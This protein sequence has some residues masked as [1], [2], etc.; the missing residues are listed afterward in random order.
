MCNKCR[1]I[2]ICR[3]HIFVFK[4]KL[5]R[6]MTKIRL[7]LTASYFCIWKSL[8]PRLLPFFFYGARHSKTFVI[9]FKKKRLFKKNVFYSRFKASMTLWISCMHG[10]LSNKTCLFF[11]SVEVQASASSPMW[12]M[13]IFQVWAWPRHLLVW[14]HWRA[15]L[16]PGTWYTA[17]GRV[18]LWHS[19]TSRLH[20]IG[21]RAR[22]ASRRVQV[23]E[24]PGST[25]I[26]TH[27]F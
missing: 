12:Y 23:R 3:S 7:R 8:K 22:P 27:R 19:N 10:Q 9:F 13:C 11:T 5:Q 18:S 24:K 15:W 1:M 2:L 16:P 26:F 25:V 20:G 21:R 4:V 6:S 17:E 14:V